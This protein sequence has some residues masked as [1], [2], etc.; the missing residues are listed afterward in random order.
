MSDHVRITDFLL[1]LKGGCNY[2]T[3]QNGKKGMHRDHLLG[4]PLEFTNDPDKE[5]PHDVLIGLIMQAAVYGN[6]ALL[7]KLVQQT[8]LDS[9]LAHKIVA[10]ANPAHAVAC[11]LPRSCIPS[12]RLDI[13]SRYLPFVNLDDDT[14]TIRLSTARQTLLSM[15]VYA[16]QNMHHGLAILLWGV[17][18]VRADV[19]AGVDVRGTPLYFAEALHMACRSCF[20]EMAEFLVVQLKTTV[21]PAT[22]LATMEN[23]YP[24]RWNVPLLRLLIPLLPQE[25]N[26]LLIQA[27]DRGKLGVVK[28][29]LHEWNVPPCQRSLLAACKALHVS[30]VQELVNAGVDVQIGYPLGHVGMGRRGDSFRLEVMHILIKAGANPNMEGTL[31]IESTRHVGVVLQH[32]TPCLMAS[33]RRREQSEVELLLRAGANPNILSV[34]DGLST[35]PLHYILG[36]I[37]D[38]PRVAV[39]KGRTAA[40]AIMSMLLQAGADPHQATGVTVAQLLDRDSTDET[41]V[42]GADIHGMFQL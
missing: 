26:P 38:S 15:F 6:R 35:T 37:R 16:C 8:T 42:F 25:H 17:K 36:V 14:T 10:Y 13:I 20:I 21:F 29:L 30:C 1:G 40:K 4:E 12:D 27:C 19:D 24:C 32:S 34:R 2:F 5:R 7:N 39:Y 28:Y 3:R 33:V 9:G 11:H 23:S 18:E 41:H 22:L 31:F